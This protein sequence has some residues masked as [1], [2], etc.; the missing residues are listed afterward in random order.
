MQ[1]LVLAD[2]ARC[3]RRPVGVTVTMVNE[4]AAA[5]AFASTN[6]GNLNKTLPAGPHDGM[7]IIHAGG[8]LQWANFPGELWLRSTVDM[9]IR[10]LS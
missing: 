8:Q 9:S 3:L 7:K 2:H 5:D 4:D 10:V 6:P 1:F